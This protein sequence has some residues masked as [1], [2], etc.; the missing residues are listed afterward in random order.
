M[1]KSKAKT[2]KSKP[3]GLPVETCMLVKP[4][5]G[6][7]P[8]GKFLRGL[9]YLIPPDCRFD[10]CDGQPNPLTLA[11]IG[12]KRLRWLEK[13]NRWSKRRYLQTAVEA[14]NILQPIDRSR[15]RD[16]YVET[17]SRPLRT[18]MSFK[19]WWNVRSQ[20][21]QGGLVPRRIGKDGRVPPTKPMTKKELKAWHEAY[22]RLYQE[23][24]K[25][26]PFG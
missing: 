15:L 11:A 20:T 9:P 14:Q 13:Q 23:W 18:G 1:S 7:D 10:A 4:A 5:I 19:D 6:G 24:K 26:N 17:T 2:K 3:Y 25:E 8:Y 16:A 21:K 12:V 22:E